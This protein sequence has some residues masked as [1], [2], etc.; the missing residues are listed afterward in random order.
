MNKISLILSD[1]GIA[2]FKDIKEE[3]EANGCKIVGEHLEIGVISLESKKSVIELKE[4]KIKG[5][6]EIVPTGPD[7]QVQ[8]PS[9]EVQ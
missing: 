6:Q 1:S 9:S 3:L 8:D 2:L 4:L 7:M 5:V